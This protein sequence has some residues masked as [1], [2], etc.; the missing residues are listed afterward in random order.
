MGEGSLRDHA[1]SEVESAAAGLG[2]LAGG[3]GE[4]GKRP[5]SKSDDF[6]DL[7]AGDGTGEDDVS[8]LVISLSSSFEALGEA[9]ERCIRLI[10]EERFYRLVGHTGGRRDISESSAQY[11]G[12]VE[13]RG[14]EYG[15]LRIP[16][17]RMVRTFGGYIKPAA[18]S[19][20]ISPTPTGAGG[21]SAA[22]FAKEA[23]FGGGASGS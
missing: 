4:M 16:G 15:S 6:M 8:Q 13:S 10:T 11:G 19:A 17:R 21:Q 12:V 7:V 9:V 14:Q 20:R 5:R 3:G 2:R 22:R 1:R 18:G 23:I